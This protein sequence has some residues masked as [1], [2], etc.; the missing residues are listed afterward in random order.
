[1]QLNLDLSHLA[2]SQEGVTAAVRITEAL[3]Q[4][5]RDVRDRATP[6]GELP[7]LDGAGIAAAPGQFF[8]VDPITGNSV[9]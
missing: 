4:Y 8:R 5:F 6:S 7:T 1:M 2:Y 3:N 9:G